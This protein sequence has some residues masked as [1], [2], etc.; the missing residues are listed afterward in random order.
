MVSNCLPKSPTESVRAPAICA[1][2]LRKVYGAGVEALKGIDLDIPAGSIFGLLGPNGAGKSTFI[3][4]LAGLVRKTSGQI[5]IWGH[6]ID[7]AR[8]SASNSIGIVPQELVIDPFF[9]PRESLENQAGYYGV[10]KA[11]RRTDEILEAMGLADKAEAYTRRLSGGMRR[12]LMVAKAMVHAPP[13]LVLDEPTAGV[14]VELRAQL[15]RYMRRLNDNGTTVLLTT[16]YLEEAEETCDRIA[17]IAGGEVV[18]CDE[19][20]ALLNRLDYKEFALVLAEDVQEVPPALTTFG[21]TLEGNRRLMLHYRPSETRVTEILAA[22]DNAGLIV[23]DIS[24]HEPDLEDL[25]LELTAG[26]GRGG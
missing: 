8:R 23:A 7:T 21:A 22:V 2:A 1:R 11:E 16:H 20:E 13:I 15:W 12:R 4:I 17:I 25:F 6:D 5:E 19:T 9:T 10:P 26:A 18:A 14:D 24:T 3:D